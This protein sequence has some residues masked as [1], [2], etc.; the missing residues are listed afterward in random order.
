VVS[1]VIPL[2]QGER[3][4]AAL[5]SSLAAQVDAPTFEVLVADN[6]STDAGR[7]VASS[8]HG[9]L[10]LRVIDAG[11]RQG[12]TYARNQGAA[13][14]AGSKLLFL[15]Q[16]DVVND[17]YVASMCAALDAHDIVG[18]RMDRFRLNPGWRAGVRQLAQET[19]LAAGPPHPWAYGGTL[20]VRRERF[21]QVGGFD[22]RLTIAAEDEDLC[23]RLQAQGA[24]IAFVPD[25]IVHYRLP[26]S[27]RALFRQGRRYGLAQVQV[28]TLHAANGRVSPTVWSQCRRILVEA[29]RAMLSPVT[30]RRWT[31]AFLL[32]RRLGTL[33]GLW[34]RRL[35]SGAR[36]P[37]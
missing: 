25:A 13:A 6:G 16:D 36:D 37:G 7:E 1:I 30:A 18:A 20:G 34:E 8:F 9:S 31:F 15:D 33:R 27:W 12:Q 2:Y 4:L 14:A 11:A 10:E 17:R 21:D 35:R 28:D 26:D 19:G 23:W 22:E 5:L 32:G 24:T 3:Y 29:P